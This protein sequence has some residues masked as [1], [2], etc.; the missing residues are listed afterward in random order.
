[1]LNCKSWLE[2]R[3]VFERITARAP[4]G[5]PRKDFEDLSESAKRRRR[6]EAF[7]Q[8]VSQCDYCK[9]REEKLTTKR[10]ADLIER[11]QL[12][13]EQFN[14]IRDIYPRLF[15]NSYKEVMEGK[16]GG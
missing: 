5:R 1:M 13:E 12:S 8:V 7:V 2:T 9:H 16:E 11:C 14:G 4:A 3:V 10:A 15:P 6:R